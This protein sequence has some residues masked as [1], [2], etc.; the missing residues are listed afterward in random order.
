MPLTKGEDFNRITGLIDER[1]GK[2]L[3][4][5]PDPKIARYFYRLKD[6]RMVTFCVEN[7]SGPQSVETI[8]RDGQHRKW[9]SY[10]EGDLLVFYPPDGADI[11]EGVFWA[12][13]KRL[14]IAV[15]YPRAELERKALGMRA[16]I[17]VPRMPA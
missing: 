10:F 11:S 16:S 3:E 12:Y 5:I 14:Q 13:D 2:V 7:A 4:L 15:E 8:S 1:S 6:D 17:L 9:Q